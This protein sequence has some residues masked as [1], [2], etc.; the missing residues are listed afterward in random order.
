MA[1]LKLKQ[2][3]GSWVE[4][5]AL[6]GA[7]GDK[8]DR[9]DRGLQ[10]IQ[11]TKGDR[12]DRG[13]DGKTAYEYAQDGGYGG[14]EAQFTEKLANGFGGLHIGSSTP[15]D[16]AD[17]W[18]D[19]NGEPT[20]VEEWE[21]DMDDGTVETKAVVVTESEDATNGN[22]AAILRVRQADGTFA[23]IP[24]LKGTKGDKG[25]K[26]DTGAQGA[27][28]DKGAQGANGKDGTNGK[29]AYEY[30][31]EGG[32][33]GTEAEFIAQLNQINDKANKTDIATTVSKAISNSA[34]SYVKISNFGDWGAGAW[35]QKGFSMLVTSR[36]G[37]TVW[38]SVSS[39]DS[40]TSAK[41]IRLMNTYTKIQKIY[42]S[43]SESAV[44]VQ[45]VAWANNVNAHILSNVNGDYVPTV[46]T[47]SALASDVV[48]IPIVEFGAASNKVV[49]G[50]STMSVEMIGSGD[51][52]TYN[53]SNMAL[54]SDIPA[55]P[56]QTENW[57][58][59]LEDGSTV[60][61]AVYVK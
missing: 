11:G 47:A 34:V 33:T 46:E 49:I 55:V 29:S 13:T 40:N 51:R 44:Y 1:I 36:A 21:F 32:Y 50:N 35:Y 56:T 18:V 43:V 22:K 14:T 61:K 37:E 15:P 27:K 23:E 60:T 28:G 42:Y 26:G 52:P 38:V 17:V 10:G 58:F 16:T 57:T 5:P 24:A 6:R 8:G 45:I 2:E 12:G 19:P 7:K 20:T 41:A 9:G 30:A 59:T 31:K 48:E 54:Q 3:D 25:D 4:V 39:N 53:G